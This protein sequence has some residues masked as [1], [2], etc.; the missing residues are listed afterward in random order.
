MLAPLGR[1]VLAAVVGLDGEEQ[2]LV[3]RQP[4]V[5]AACLL[6]QLAVD[7][8]RNGTLGGV[9]GRLLIGCSS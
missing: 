7:Q 2:P 6:A 9:L 4:R 3:A 5:L 8:L 1:G